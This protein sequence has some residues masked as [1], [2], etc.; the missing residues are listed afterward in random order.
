VQ[1]VSDDGR[2]SALRDS[3]SYMNNEIDMPRHMVDCAD[4]WC[5]C[6]SKSDWCPVPFDFVTERFYSRRLA[7]IAYIACS[8]PIFVT[9]FLWLSSGSELDVVAD[10]QVDEGV[11]S[12]SL[13]PRSLLRGKFCE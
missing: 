4:R 5:C 3:T 12:L 2:F 1:V 6:W 13:A 9:Y 8:W 11:L 10:C 7:V